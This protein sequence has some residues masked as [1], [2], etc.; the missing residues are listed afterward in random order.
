METIGCLELRHLD[1][2][3]HLKKDAYWSRLIRKS[4]KKKT[5]INICY[6][7]QCESYIFTVFK[8]IKKINWLM[9]NMYGFPLSCNIRISYK[10]SYV[11]RCHIFFF[12]SQ[13][14]ILPHWPAFAMTWWSDGAIFY[15]PV[16]G[17]LWCWVSLQHCTE[18]NQWWP[19]MQFVG[20]LV[21]RMVGGNFGGGTPAIF[22]FG[23][24]M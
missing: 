13:K 18:A 9:Y 15:G 5:R 11:F 20:W 17:W 7:T 14:F 24:A 4:F 22:L 21:R 1:V 16:C 8:N 23:G 6:S 3:V 2:E 12:Q 19:W 10:Q